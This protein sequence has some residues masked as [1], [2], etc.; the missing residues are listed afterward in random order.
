MTTPMTINLKPLSDKYS[1]LVDPTMYK[2]L[3]GSL[4]YLV[5]IM[6]DICFAM[7]TLS[8]HM[9]EPKHVH[10]MEAKHMLRYL[11]GTY[12]IWIEICLG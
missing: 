11:H 7:N 2:M 8:Q 6:P 9:V 12:H 4:M 1:Y 3:I 10:W 5:N